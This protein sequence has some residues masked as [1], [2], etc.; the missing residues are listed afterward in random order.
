MSEISGRKP[1]R[2]DLD[3]FNP[4]FEK[5]RKSMNLEKRKEEERKIRLENEVSRVASG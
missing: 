5:Y 3:N 1:N 2:K 4:E